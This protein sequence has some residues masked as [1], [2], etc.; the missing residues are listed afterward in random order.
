MLFW[1]A[2]YL[3]QELY[4]ASTAHFAILCM[5]AKLTLEGNVPTGLGFEASQVLSLGSWPRPV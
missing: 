3:P 4:K 5:V 1:L 2:S